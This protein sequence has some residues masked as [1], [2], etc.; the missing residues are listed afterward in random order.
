MPN[1][2]HIRIS[3]N[4]TIGQPDFRGAQHETIEEFLARRGV[5]VKIRSNCWAEYPYRRV[6]Q[7]FSRQHL[8]PR[9][10]YIVSERE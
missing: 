4:L 10:F 6:R 1:K 8:D 9:A 5:I 7:T 3:H 2:G